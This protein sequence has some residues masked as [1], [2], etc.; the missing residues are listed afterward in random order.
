M[1]Y[2]STYQDGFF[3]KETTLRKNVCILTL[4]DRDEEYVKCHNESVTNYCNKHGYTYIFQKKYNSN[5]PIY[6]HKLLFVRDHLS[7][8]D[9]VMW[10]DSDTIIYDDNIRLEVLLNDKHI[11]LG[12]TYPGTIFSE[13][14]AGIFI[15]RNSPEGHSFIND[16]LENYLSNKD[17]M[18][19]GR[20]VLKG[21]WAGIC[22]EQGVMNYMARF[23]WKHKNNTRSIPYNI[24]M[25][26]NIIEESGFIL[27]LCGEGQV[28]IPKVYKRLMNKNDNKNNKNI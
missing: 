21:K 28:K 10:L 2:I 17:C 6:W 3:I 23:I 1:Y 24:F 13:Y 22:Y 25:S 5:L 8:Y 7:E 11:Y 16:C 15:I 18:K 19:N 12:S 27:H 14:N 20:H 9:Y 26:N 4:E